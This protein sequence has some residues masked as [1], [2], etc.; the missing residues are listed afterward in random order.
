[1][2]LALAG[3]LVVLFLLYIVMPFS[4]TVDYS[5]FFII[6]MAT[7]VC[8]FHD[9]VLNGKMYLHVCRCTC[10]SSKV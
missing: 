7:C 5:N 8:P 9:Q 2:I 4:G 6:V 3:G 1:M 10:L